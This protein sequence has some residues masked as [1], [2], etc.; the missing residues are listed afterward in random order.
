[1]KAQGQARFEL[2]TNPDY[3]S[4]DLCICNTGCRVHVGRGDDTSKDIKGGHHYWASPCL[5]ACMLIC[6]LVAAL[7]P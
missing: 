1:M 6:F 7:H 2:P 4:M 5:A 3:T